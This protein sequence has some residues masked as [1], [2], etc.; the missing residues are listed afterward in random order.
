MLLF[1]QSFFITAQCPATTG[2]ANMCHNYFNGY[3]EYG[4]KVFIY[5][6]EDP[7]IDDTSPECPLPS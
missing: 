5:V 4:N 3:D 7:W 1:M 2:P 6:C